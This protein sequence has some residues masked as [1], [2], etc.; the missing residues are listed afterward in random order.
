MIR[1]LCNSCTCRVDIWVPWRPQACRLGCHSLVFRFVGHAIDNGSACRV[2]TL[3]VHFSANAPVGFMV[4]HLRAPLRRVLE[5]SNASACI[6][7]FKISFNLFHIIQQL[8]VVILDTSPYRLCGVAHHF[9]YTR[10]RVCPQGRR[11]QLGVTVQMPSISLLWLAIFR[12]T[13]ALD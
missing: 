1:T 11:Q 3:L 8:R 10:F 5:H 2:C 4:T 7:H 12:S 6:V 9:A 13:S